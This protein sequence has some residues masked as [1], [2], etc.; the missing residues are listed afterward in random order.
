M[1][2][3]LLLFQFLFLLSSTISVNSFAQESI[4]PPL[5]VSAG[6]PIIK[7]ISSYPPKANF[8]NFDTEEG[9][10]L[11][12]ITCG[13]MDKKGNLWWGTDGG[14]VSHYDGKKF[15]NFTT[16]QGL[17]HNSIYSITEDR[18]GNIWLGTL[19]GG[20]SHYD[21]K[22]FTTFTTEQGLVHDRIF[23]I[24]EDKAGNIW[25]GTDRGG[26]SRYDGSSFA[27]F[28]TEHGLANNRVFSIMEDSKGNIWL[29]TLGGGVSQYDGKNFTNFTTDQGLVSNVITSI[30]EDENGNLWFGSLGDGASRY[31][32]SSFS[33]FTTEQGLADNSIYSITKDKSG[34]IWFGTDEGGVSRYNM[35]SSKLPCQS[36]T[37]NHNLQLR[38]E[39]EK[40]NQELRK[41][42]TTF[43]ND[44]GLAHSSVWSI[45][46]DNS[47]SI[48]F[49]TYGG[50][51]SRYDGESFVSYNTEHGL[52]E[53]SV[54]SIT[55]DR[56]GN[57]WF[58]TS[59]GGVTRYDGENL[60]TFTTAQGLP[61]DRVYCIIEDKSGNMWFGSNGGGVT[62][63]DGESFTIFTTAQ[64]LA[65]DVINTISNDSKGNI[66]LGTAGGGVSRYDGKSFTNFTTEAGLAHNSVWNITEDESGDIWFGTAGG[67]ISRYDGHSFTNFNTQHGLADNFINNITKDVK[68]NLWIGTSGGGL[69]VL[70]QETINELSTENTT[71][72]EKIKSGDKIFHNITKADGL[73]DLVVYDMIETPEGNMVFGTNLGY[74]ILIG[75]AKNLDKEKMEWEY[76][77]NKT[78]YPIK[79]LNTNAMCI[80]KTGFPYKKS[81][82]NVGI[83]WGGCG[84]DK[85]IR[86]DPKAVKRNANPLPVFIQKVKINE[87]NI[88]WYNLEAN[89]H[90]STT[91]S[92]QEVITHGQLLSAEVRD[93]LRTKYADIQFEGID[94][95][96]FLPENL[97][98][99]SRH[100]SI[101]F[102]F[103]GIETA[104]NFM[105]RY[106]Y[107][108]EGYDKDW[109]PVT[110][111]TSATFGNMYE[112]DYIFKLRARSPEGIWS[113]PVSYAFTVLPPWWRTWW[114]YLIYGTSAIGLI[115]LIVWWNGRRLRK[116]AKELQKEVRKATKEI[117]KK[118]RN[119][120]SANNEITEQKKVVEE[121]HKEIT[122]SI[123]YA[124]RIQDSILPSEETLSKDL[125][126]GFLL[127][128]PKDVVAGDFYW[129]EQYH[130]K[131][132]FAAA[133]CTG[134]GV[135]GALV[136]M[137]C[138]NA[139]SKTLLEENITETGKLL[140]RTRELVIERFA[141]SGGEVEDGMDISLCALDM[142]TMILQWSGANNPLWVMRN[143]NLLKHKADRMPIGKY[144]A[145]RPFSTHNFQLEKND[146]IYVFSDG[147][148]DQ[149]GGPNGKKFMF[150]QLD[151]LL[152][153]IYTRKMNEQKEILQKSFEDW[154]GD[155][156]QVDDV[157]IIGVKVG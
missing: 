68:G 115:G 104:K 47:G 38:Q 126:D 43:T 109:S 80:I 85:L 79:D 19:G 90:D 42:F 27:N 59:G 33:S 122:D 13:F 132:F 145:P 112:G 98:L 69:S 82:E 123:H 119:L 35:K 139:L 111:R 75:G 14:G 89:T 103:A 52:F 70:K 44:Q 58:G 48:W 110:S 84:D 17:A 92:Q 4:S 97:I 120:E 71:T 157:C 106:Q 18:N 5:T 94:K 83:I 102:D 121:K 9:L 2:T 60:A 107:I 26:V 100:N 74:S 91:L 156:E 29:G 1:K 134:H 116:R 49:G 143:G 118:N 155:L 144:P 77:N 133:D 40:H 15:T 149:F 6:T 140:D 141:K 12:T 24:I 46:E 36:N 81:T 137:V 45:T 73:A 50:G 64:G 128:L 16:E 3:N 22:T 113:T 129:M 151:K 96:F 23:R 76:Y 78:G 11:G 65:H 66:W 146:I 136:S 108:L 34:D 131:V 31:N 63:Y 93:S 10:A 135:P 72:L 99:P 55:E 86:F 130:G 30:T 56:K 142:K 67:G 127:Y 124:K 125:K 148:P 57:L 152:I 150:K 32:G 95:N 105:V 25:M 20:V 88:D 39:L 28:T 54:F 41:S 8:T 7:Q 101:G 138:S 53:N 62:R 37:C 87:N 153:S 21:G 51:V 114:M 117:Q 61:N 147:Y 154:K